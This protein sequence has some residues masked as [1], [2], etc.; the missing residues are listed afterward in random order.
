MSRLKSATLLAIL[1]LFGTISFGLDSVATQDDREAL[2]KKINEVVKLD[3]DELIKKLD[4]TWELYDR[5]L[6]AVLKT[7]LIEEKEFVA[8]VVLLVQEED[9]PKN[10]VD[11]AWLWVRG[12]RPGT[13]YP[14]VYFE[15]VLRLQGERAN[16]L[17]PPFNRNVYSDSNS[18]DRRIEQQARRFR[19]GRQ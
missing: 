17:I 18:I 8:R 19:Q 10:L 5:Q 6:Q 12:K 2:E 15:R 1:V 9:I 13:K 3:L 11:S 7:R 16:I 14:F 4:D